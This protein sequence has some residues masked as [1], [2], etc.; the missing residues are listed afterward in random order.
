MIYRNE[1]LNELFSKIDQSF[2]VDILDMFHIDWDYV[3]LKSTEI[4]RLGSD[5][6]IYILLDTY[7]LRYPIGLSDD[8]KNTDITVCK[9]YNKNADYF[10]LFTIYSKPEKIV[11]L[12][13][14][15]NDLKAFV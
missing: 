10:K 4:D 7:V 12:L 8:I 13:N 14:K 3:I 5:E 1:E 15:V 11:K 9:Y 2:I 6:G